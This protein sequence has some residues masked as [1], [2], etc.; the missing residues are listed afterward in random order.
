MA[1]YALK[2]NADFREAATRNVCF[3][4]QWDQ[5]PFLKPKVVGQLGHQLSGQEKEVLLQATLEKAPITE[6][7]LWRNGSGHSP[8]TRR[9]FQEQSWIN[10]TILFWERPNCSLSF[11]TT[12]PVAETNKD[13]P[14]ALEFT[15]K[16]HYPH[17][18]LK[19]PQ[20][21]DFTLSERQGW[22]PMTKTLCK[23]GV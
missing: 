6:S 22:E 1:K 15:V 21:N 3:W 11:R 18:P 7:D 5:G 4:N 20:F 10:F 23:Q 8:F 9:S 17:L 2:W 16:C 13:Q 19:N 14:K 12:G